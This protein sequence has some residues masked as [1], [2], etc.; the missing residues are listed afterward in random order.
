[1]NPTQPDRSRMSKLLAPLTLHHRV[2]ALERE[3]QESRKLNQRLSDVVDV[4]TEIL[5]PA[6]DRDDE[7]MRAALARLDAAVQPPAREDVDGE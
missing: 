6:A 5:V 3:V 1:M 4:I 2:V 7:R